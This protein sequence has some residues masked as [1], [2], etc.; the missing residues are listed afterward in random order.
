MPSHM[1]RTSSRLQHATAR[2]SLVA[3][4]ARH[5]ITWLSVARLAS[6]SPAP[7]AAVASA[8]GSPV[9]ACHHAR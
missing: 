1:A 2:S 6:D 4:A 3:R 9:A 8:P 7:A 5:G